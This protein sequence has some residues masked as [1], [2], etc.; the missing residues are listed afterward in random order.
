RRDDTDS[1]VSA[2][3]ADAS[4]GLC[5][6]YGIETT[7]GR[8]G[9]AVRTRRAGSAL[10]VLLHG[11]AG[12]GRDFFG[13]GVLGR[14]LVRG[15]LLGDGLGGRAGGRLLRGLVGGGRLDDLLDL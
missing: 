9:R 8:S 12:D 6:S 2:A 1:N 10:R 11:L 14:L 13:G 3:P 4:A 15:D 7:R 5:S